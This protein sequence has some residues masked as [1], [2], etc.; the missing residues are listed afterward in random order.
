[1]KIKAGGVDQR[2]NASLLLSTTGA[3]VA[4][5][6]FGALLGEALRPIAAAILVLGILA[7]LIGM[8]GNR[9]AQLSTGYHFRW[10][11]V[12]AYWLCWALIGA[13]GVYLAMS[14]AGSA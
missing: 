11:E 4:G 14:L 10:W 1:M 2:R 12:G 8:F 3:V 5:I 6:G 13:L 7:H 9:R